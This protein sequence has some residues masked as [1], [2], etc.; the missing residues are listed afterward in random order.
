MARA[1]L[2]V[3]PDRGS[4]GRE[5]SETETAEREMK[6]RQARESVRSAR[7]EVTATAKRILRRVSNPG[8]P[9]VTAPTPEPSS[10]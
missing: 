2:H 4:D 9:A 5:P 6:A 8:M 7:K 10:K 3:R 1:Q